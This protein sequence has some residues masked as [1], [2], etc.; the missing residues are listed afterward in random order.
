MDLAPAPASARGASARAGHARAVGSWLTGAD[1]R[2]A[3]V[4]A[5]QGRVGTLGDQV[6]L[7]CYGFDPS[8]GAYT[9]AIHRALALAAALTTAALALGIAWLSAPRSVR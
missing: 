1:V 3:L 8:V 4:D 9:Q 5:G 2:L 7:L 6:R